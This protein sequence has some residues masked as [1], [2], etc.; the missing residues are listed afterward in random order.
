MKLVPVFVDFETYW[1]VTHSLSKINP[2]VYCTHKDTE[3]I[4]CSIAVGSKDAYVVFGE[5][6][7]R[8][9]F[10]AI[11]WSDKIVIAHNMS[12]FDAMILAWRFG[13]A[14]AMWG[15][16]LAMA[17]PLHSLTVGNSIAKL[18]EHY[19]LGVKDNTA[20][21]NTK[22]K[23]L[24]DFT[25]AELRAMS[26]YNKAD[27]IQCAK[28]F[29]ILRKSTSNTEMK[30]IDLTIRMLV[31]P[32]LVVDKELLLKTYGEEQERKKKSLEL[33][34]KDMGFSGE[35]DQA[36]FVRG[37]LASAA[38][39]AAQLRK[40]G[41]EP[42]MKASP[43]KP[44]KQTYAL[45]KTDQELLA[46]QD[47]D[48]PLVAAATR[49]RLDVKSTILESR[50]S[51][52]LDVSEAVHGRMPIAKNYYAA[53]TG[54]WGGSMGLNQENLPRIPYDKDG[55]VVER[56]SNALRFSLRAP[57]RHKVVVADLSGIELRV[58]HFLWKVPYSTKLWASDANADLYRAAGAV[59]Y[60]CTPAEVTKDQRQLEKVKALGLG[61][62]AGAA[63]FR[64]VAKLM[65]GI[66]L[67]EIEAMD[68]VSSW[69][70]KHPEIVTGWKICHNALKSIDF[71]SD[72]QLDDWGL[73]STS[74]EGIRT[75][76]GLIRYPDLRKEAVDG[77]EEWWYG[78]GRNKTRIYAGKVTENIVQH[79]ARCILGDIMLDVYSKTGYRP[80]HSVH[81]EL[82][83]VVPSEDADEQLEAVQ[84]AMRTPPVWW[85]EL[86]TW[87]EGDVA[88]SYGA[89][90]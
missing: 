31:E 44:E 59:E 6:A 51:S 56:P 68:T 72:K 4:S 61:F 32:K 85:P 17:R 46:L 45:A 67:S 13:V 78:Q 7:I 28:L 22:G 8:S 83:Y 26:E 35:G 40:W 1:S 69:R 27:T 11:N 39:F 25:D 41:V 49:A 24:R 43:T 12:G 19:K 9:E 60:R 5:A 65:G 16:T 79:L 54:R 38:K 71:G 75:P 37:E 57:K 58:N 88:D 42:P 36:E 66:D 76:K 18:V 74:A 14:P 84:K 48:N 34:A 3:I 2:I 30:L 63:T 53:H 70:S 52:F 86:V 89:A 77:K 73:C 47:H 87:S 90:K 33:L 80:T 50:I 64:R 81:D 20:L 10:E 62:G 82:V 23:K 15:C 55:K 21:L 29:H